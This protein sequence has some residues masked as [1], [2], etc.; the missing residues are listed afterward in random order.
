LKIKKQDT[1][2]IISGKD[3]GKTGKVVAILED[4][5][6]VEGV[7]IIKKHKKKKQNQKDPGGIITIEAP[8]HI[9]KVMLICPKTNKPTRVGYKLVNGK[10]SRFSKKGKTIIN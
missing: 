5:I 8:I 2:K 9:S 10:K 1:V 6:V 4:K 7:N 3:R